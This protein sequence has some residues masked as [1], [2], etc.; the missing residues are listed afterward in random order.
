[1]RTT[2]E[3]IKF[4]RIDCVSWFS[5]RF[6]LQPIG[7]PPAVEFDAAHFRRDHAPPGIEEH[8]QLSLGETGRLPA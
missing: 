7:H 4:A 6:L 2:I 3:D 5:M 1:M 8:T